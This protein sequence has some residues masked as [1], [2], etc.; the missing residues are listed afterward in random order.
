MN[1]NSKTL[2][3]HIL[4]TALCLG[5]FIFRLGDVGSNPKGFFCDEAAIAYNAKSIIETGKDEHGKSFPIYFK[6]YGDYKSATYIYSVALS[7]LFF[8]SEAVEDIHFSTRFPA[9]LFMGLLLP[10]AYLILA[11]AIHPTCGLLA[12]LLLGSAPWLH[13]FS[14]IGFSLCAIPFLLGTGFYFWLLAQKYSVRFYSFSAAL[15]S[16]ALYTYAPARVFVP[17]FSLG[18]LTIYFPKK[19]ESKKGLIVFLATAAIF[20][21]PF[22][23]YVLNEGDFLKRVEYLNVF[24]T[25]HLE[26]SAGFKWLS[27]VLAEYGYQM[28]RGDFLSSSLVAAWNYLQYLSPH[29][30]FFNAGGNMRFGVPKFGLLSILHGAGLF[31]GILFALKRRDKLDFTLLWWILIFPIPGALTWEDIPHAGRSIV[32]HPGIDLLATIGLW[33]TGTLILENGSKIRII[34]TAALIIGASTLHWRNSTEYFDYYTTKYSRDSSGWMQYGFAEMMQYINDNHSNY[35]KTVLVTHFLHYEPE[36]F[37]LIYGNHPPKEWQRNGELPWNLE[38]V[39]KKLN[40]SNL[41]E[42]VLYI[43]TP[44]PKVIPSSAEEIYSVTWEDGKSKAFSVV[45]KVSKLQS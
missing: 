37:A 10:I 9:A 40:L 27:P 35:K 26:A 12:I 4:A 44:P 20:A 13:H 31:L 34:A 29:H 36:M 6:S 33:R 28:N 14:H 38:V 3:Y 16:I 24:G 18:L 32:S 11:L 19:S 21:I 2:F 30:I 17:L 22:I 23:F 7:Q 45:H 1:S 42:N 39:R 41:E 5:F 15:F 43:F 25:P 8:G